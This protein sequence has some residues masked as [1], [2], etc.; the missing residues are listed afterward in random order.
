MCQHGLIGIAAQLSL[1]QHGQV[2]TEIDDPERPPRIRRKWPTTLA[3]LG[4]ARPFLPR[5]LP[6]P[7]TPTSGLE[8]RSRNRPIAG[9]RNGSVRS[10][11]ATADCRGEQPPQ[12]C[13][14]LTAGA[15]RSRRTSGSAKVVFGTGW[16]RHIN[17]GK[18]EG[19]TT[20]ERAQ[21]TRLRRE[22]RVL[23]ME[24]RRALSVARS[25]LSPVMTTPTTLT[26]DRRA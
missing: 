2:K 1:V 12:R 4:R 13:P 15:I 26:L 8:K 6:A 18:R 5:F 19:L 10:G 9:P 23:N 22:N 24:L 14:H 3:N 7:P 16:P 21:L 17:E 11:N 20:E 25:R